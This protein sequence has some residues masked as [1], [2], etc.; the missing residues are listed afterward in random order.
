MGGSVSR[1]I[2][3]VVTVAVALFAFA[4]SAHATPIT[5]EMSSVASGK[6]GATTFTN[7][8]VDLIARGNTANITPVAIPVGMTTIDGFANPFTSFKVTIQG[9]GTATISDPSAIWYF[10]V[11]GGP[12]TAPSIFFGRIDVPPALDSLTA[13]GFVESPALAGYS[14]DS[15]IGPLTGA[16]NIGFDPLCSTG[17]N[18]PCIHTSLGLLSF[19]ANITFPPTGE[20]T[21]VSAPVPEPTTLFLLG[22]G[23]VALAGRCRARSRRQ[24]N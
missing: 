9:V 8:E 22:S 4:P 15:E 13:I 24:K 21:F 16:G 7:A 20:A 6:I 23:V 19:T 3:C 1:I 12:I 5:Y 11:V 2:A 14:L 17:M 18:D 10:P